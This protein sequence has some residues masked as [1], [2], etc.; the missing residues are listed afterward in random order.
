[1]ED[2]GIW[3]K[4]RGFCRILEPRTK[5]CFW[6]WVTVICIVGAILMAATALHPISLLF[7][8]VAVLIVLYELT[9][10]HTVEYEVRDR[11]I[12]FK[13]R[14][15]FRRHG[16]GPLPI[17]APN[18]TLLVYYTVRG[19]YSLQFEQTARE[20]KRNIGRIYFRG[21]TE[22]EAERPFTAYERG[23]I[24]IP[25]VHAAYGV[26]RFDQVREALQ[27]RF[28]PATPTDANESK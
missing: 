21:A 23:V 24:P 17:L 15:V 4:S 11:A 19:I 26:A 1:M 20:K 18:A 16:R 7:I 22:I 13:K 9:H 28:L 10:K 2:A 8:P 25:R 27:T 6:I 12:C 14:I 5:K 3:F